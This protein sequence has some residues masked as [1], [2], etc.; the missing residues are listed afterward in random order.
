M[1][2][3]S[4]S[5]S[6]ELVFPELGPMNSVVVHH[7][8]QLEGHCAICWR[9]ISPDNE[10]NEGSE[11]NSLCGDCKCMLLEDIDTNIRDSHH[12]STDG[13]RVR[14]SRSSESIEDLFSQQFSHLIN[15]VRQN[16]YS[17][18]ISSSEHEVQLTNGDTATRVLQRTSSRTTPS[19]S[20]RW[21]RVL[22]DNESE[23]FDNLDSVFG[24]SESNVSFSGYGAFHTE[25]DAVSFSAYGGESD[26]SVDGHGLLDREM[27][28]HPDD[29][30]DIDSDTDIDPMHAGLNQWNLDD[31]QDGE[32]EEADAEGSTV[33][34][35]EAEGW[36]QDAHIRSPTENNAPINWFR[37]INSPESRGLIHLRF[38]ESRHTYI[39]DI[40]TSL[41]ESDVRPYYVGNPGDY[42]DTRG[43][44]ELLEQLAETDSFRRGAPP[45]SANFV[46]CLPLVVINEEHEKL[47]SLVCAVCKDSILVG[48]EANRLPCM[49]LYHPSCILPWLSARNSCPL[50]RYELPTDDKDYED[51]KHNTG[52]GV[53]IHEIQPQD[54]GNESSS[55]FSDDS[56]T[57]ELSDISNGRTEGGELVNGECATD[58]SGRETRRGGWFFFA[59]APIVS[60]VGIVLVLWF[61]NPLV[62]RRG[63]R[64]RHAFPEQV[65]QHVGRTPM[66]D[67]RGNRSRRWWPFF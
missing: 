43:F 59:A 58:T 3:E 33:E 13:G 21:R 37:G 62:E 36:I 52:S 55:D 16:Q 25:S 48:T 17:V 61:R 27:F 56:E 29:G 44:E 39:P 6:Q 60:L 63:P 22:S 41:E 64:G 1:D 2:A 15:L 34:T 40:F 46:E 5:I 10:I 31:P 57:D 9:V 51:G 38:R 66:H 49:H 19:G 23:V 45:A 26:A 11:T 32:W 47:G 18:P 24:E 28:L 30:S 20:R 53:G 12:R 7:S 50:C 65:Q 54:Q 35:T 8:D 4:H 14:Y 67:Q 42:L